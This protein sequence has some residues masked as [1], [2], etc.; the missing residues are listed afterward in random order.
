MN[1]RT[2]TRTSLISILLVLVTFNGAFARHTDGRHLS[3]SHSVP[4]GQVAVQNP[5]QQSAL[6]MIATLTQ[7]ADVIIIGRVA[8]VASRL[9]KNQ[10]NDE[11][12]VSDV[13]IEPEE[14]L[15]GQM[16]SGQKIAL[17]DLQSG[18]MGGISMSS[19]DAPFFAQNT[20]VVLFLKSNSG[21]LKVID[22]ETGKFD[23]DD[24]GQIPEVGRSLAQMRIEILSY[25]SGSRVY[26]PIV[27][28]KTIPAQFPKTN[29]EAQK[30]IEDVEPQFVLTGRRWPDASPIVNFSIN[31]PG[32]NDEGAG[33]IQQ[34]NQALSDAAN[35]W[36]TQGQANITAQANGNT[37]ITNVAVDETNAIIV[38]NATNPDNT[39]A[40]ATARWSWDEQGRILD[41]DIVFWD[42]PHAFSAIGLANATDIQSVATHEIG[43]CLGLGHSPVRDAVMFES[44]RAGEIKRQLHQDDVFGIQTIYGRRNAGDQYTDLLLYDTDGT[45]GF[46]ATTG[47]GGWQVLRDYHDWRHWSQIVPGN[48]N[49]DQYTDLLLYDTDGTAG[50]IA[51]TGDGGWQVLRDYHDWR[52]WSQIVPGRFN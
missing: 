20:R 2:Y 15:K 13:T 24:S 7:Q 45:A 6:A 51:T 1:R 3:V 9:S 16:A 19:S 35:T 50:F 42:E 37:N 52:H 31:N 41:C 25:L 49:G 38:R 5:G 23:I 12:I 28:S 22:G 40:L 30:S 27:S 11:L 46:I 4:G 44:I 29:A 14:A 21:G 48:F 32:F 34:Q 18:S 43:H 8:I 36:N 26:L 33:T 47:D 10:Y 39:N 17:K